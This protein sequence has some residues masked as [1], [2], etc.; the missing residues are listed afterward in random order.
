MADK[1]YCGNARIVTTKF[2]DITKVSMSK[3]DINKIVKYMKE[4][5]SNWINLEVIEKKD[6]TKGKATHYVS[7]DTWK[8]EKREE[9]GLPPSD[10]QPGDDEGDDLPF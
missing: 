2:G 5:D 10:I 1:I 4:G 3:D 6:P 7:I 9:T 8:P